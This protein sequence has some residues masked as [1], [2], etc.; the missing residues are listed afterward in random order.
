MS[1][2]RIGRDGLRWSTRK[3]E[4][5][6]AAAASWCKITGWAG[7]SGKEG[8]GRTTVGGALGVVEVPAEG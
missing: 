5:V 1:M 3:Q 7:G 4:Q 6:W 2:S 8:K